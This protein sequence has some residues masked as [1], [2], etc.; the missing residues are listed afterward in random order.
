MPLCFEP[1]KGT[2]SNTNE[3]CII[4]HGGADWGSHTMLAGFSHAYKYG[5][6][7]ALNSDVGMNC[8]LKGDDF[9]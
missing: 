7:V 8:N 1:V 4:G 2:P 6:T 3:T 9:Q 5:I